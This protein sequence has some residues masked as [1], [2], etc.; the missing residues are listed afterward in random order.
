MKNKLDQQG[1]VALNERNNHATKQHKA[2]AKFSMKNL[3]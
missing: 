3:L 1:M 2:T